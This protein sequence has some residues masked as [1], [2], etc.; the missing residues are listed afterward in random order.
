MF[1]SR[2]L[3][4]ILFA[5]ATLAA[6]P[7]RA[8]DTARARTEFLAGVDYVKNA[9][10]GEALASFER[11]N[12]LR[13]HPLTTFNIGACERA[14]GRYTRARL[15]LTKALAA[16]D[17]A[18]GKDLAPS[19][20]NDAKTWIAEI[21]RLI[22]QAHVTVR[23]S[24][25]TMLVDGKPP[26]PAL[27][28]GAA[29]LVLDPGS[30]V[31]SLSRTGFNAVVVT[32]TLEPGSK[33]QIVLDMQSLPATL[34]VAADRPNAVVTVD[35][36]DVGV[37]PVQLTRPAGTYTIEVRKPGFVTYKSSV[38]VGPGE[39][40]SIRANLPEE[41]EAITKKWW[42]WGG[43]AVIVAGA[44]VGTYLVARPA[45]ERPAPNGGALGWVV[46]V[47]TSK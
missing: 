45:P 27:S 9:R 37:A 35:E 5:V 33:P 24:D 20:V 25:A 11:S 28:G 7:A 6:T 8:D 43:A 2:T 41:H 10:W 22:V 30:H 26:E 34:R 21:D 17:A 15:T 3:A 44:A 12:E 23:P 4:A 31:F 19:F 36:L 46:T 38:K 42:F 47:P 40:P 1:R 29:V 32:K 18:G 16:N 39:E 13:S 14:L